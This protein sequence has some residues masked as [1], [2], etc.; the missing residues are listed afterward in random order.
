MTPTINLII[1]AAIIFAV[2]LAAVIVA[3]WRWIAATNE[4]LAARDDGERM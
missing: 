1:V 3:V 4:R 2:L